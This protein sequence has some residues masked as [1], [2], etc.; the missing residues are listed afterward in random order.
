MLERYIEAVQVPE[1]R[2][3]ALA[4]AR[5]E[6]V[7]EI[8]VTDYGVPPTHLTVADA[9]PPGPPGVLLELTPAP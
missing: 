6:A 2:L 1:E 5:A 7:R 4:R 3:T 8:A 9:A